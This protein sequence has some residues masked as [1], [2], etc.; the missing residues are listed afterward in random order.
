MYM[1]ES[2]RFLRMSSFL[3]IP[4]HHKSPSIPHQSLINTHHPL[5]LNMSTDYKFEGWLG[6]DE[7]AIGNMK[8]GEFEPKKWSENDVDIKIS[9]CGVC[10]SDLHTLK[11]GWG[12]TPY[13]ESI[14]QAYDRVMTQ[15]AN[16]ML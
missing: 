7:K 3:S 4:L 5:I 12:P 14:Q 16:H 11:S 9:H 15:L 6:N 1:K 2:C 8:W 10:G 13:R